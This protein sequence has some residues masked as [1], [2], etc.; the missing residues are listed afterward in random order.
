MALYL[1]I[2][3]QSANILTGSVLWDVLER[4]GLIS[5]DRTTTLPPTS[6]WR[7]VILR[8]HSI[9][10]TQ[11]SMHCWL[12]EL[13]KHFNDKYKNDRIVPGFLAIYKKYNVYGNGNTWNF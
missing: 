11:R 7:R 2:I 5:S 4:S 10:A 6:L 12:R 9:E 13:T 1:A 3:F 8:V